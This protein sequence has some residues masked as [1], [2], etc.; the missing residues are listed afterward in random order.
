[1]CSRA[2]SRR[3]IH[4]QEVEEVVEERMRAGKRGNDILREIVRSRYQRIDS[5]GRILEHCLTSLPWATAIEEVPI[6]KP[7]DPRW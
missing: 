7:N 4:G 6:S 2:S 3:W 5:L 1:M